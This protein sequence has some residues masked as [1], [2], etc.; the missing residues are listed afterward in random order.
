MKVA[1]PETRTTRPGWLLLLVI[2]AVLLMSLWFREGDAG[3]LHRVRV[4]TQAV[5][6]PV[7]SVGMWASGPFRSF[8]V[9][10]GDLGVS[11]SELEE[12]RTQNENLRARVAELE[13]ARLE[14]E[15][16]SELLANATAAGQT[17][18]TGSIIGLPPNAWSQVITI[19]VGSRS[20]VEI[21][22]PVVGPNGLVGLTIEVGPNYSRVRLITDQNSGVAALIQRDRILGIAKG[23]P[24]G[25]ITLDFVD[26]GET[27]VIGDVVLTSGR[28]GLFPR[29]LLVGQVT[30]VTNPANALYQ[31]IRIQPSNDIV[32][33]EEVLVLT[34]AAPATESIS[35]DV[36]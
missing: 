7:S 33:T 15:R 25:E 35:G 14:N 10:V 8:T 2:L 20:G 26:G 24:S 34:G 11:R 18:V 5:A 6:A 22:M 29:G 3:P 9:W 1:Q 36:Q 21:D 13:E 27:V 31:S 16:L 17:G 30:D 23:S 12:L 19:D 28:G 4:A 32:N